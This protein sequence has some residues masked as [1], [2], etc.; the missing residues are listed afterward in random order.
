ML[1][2]DKVSFET[3]LIS[4]DKII[5]YSSEFDEPCSFYNTKEFEASI[6]NFIIISEIAEKISLVVQENYSFI[7]WRGIKGFRNIAAHDYF[8]LD[9][10]EV[11]DIIHNDLPKLQKEIKEIISNF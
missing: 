10:K 4:I 5:E 11:W 3:I 1:N 8:G 7:D 2:R 6:M 9:V